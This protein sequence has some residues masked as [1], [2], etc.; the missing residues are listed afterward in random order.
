MD[1]ATDRRVADGDNIQ[2]IVGALKETGLA[3]IHDYIAPGDIT[4]EGP[5]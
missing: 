3:V 2:L 5:D 4:Q 1:I